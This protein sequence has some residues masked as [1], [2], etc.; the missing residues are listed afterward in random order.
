MVE[1]IINS[2]VA[3]VSTNLDY[4][5]VLVLLIGT[6]KKTK[7]ILA[8]DLI[9]TSFLTILPMIIA[10]ILGSVPQM[11][12]IGLLGIFPIIFGIKELLPKKHYSNSNIETSNDSTYTI[13][14]K[15]VL[16][17]ITACGAD[18][19]AVYIP[20]FIK[21]TNIELIAAF[22]V[23]LLMAVVFFVLATKI[24]DNNKV[25]H[26]LNKY[27]KYLSAVIYIML[28]ISVLAQNGTIKHFL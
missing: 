18:N 23:M 22:I 12:V 14:I 5:L 16:I 15:T 21:K 20:I 17:T 11:W 27:G 24:G 2:I 19:V 4:I 8:G 7:P 25:K 10:R 3:Y 26:I 6:Y 9:G 1:I 13:V 28:G